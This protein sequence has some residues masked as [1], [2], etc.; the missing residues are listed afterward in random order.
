MQINTMSVYW[1]ARPESAE[2]CT[3]RL[4]ACFAEL[5]IHFPQ[6]AD[7]Y[8][9]GVKKATVISE[10]PVNKWNENALLEFVAASVNR[11]DIGEEAIVALGFSFGLCNISDMGDSGMSVTCGLFSPNPGLSNSVVVKL[12]KDLQTVSLDAIESQKR[13]LL[14]LVKAWNADW[15]AGYSSHSAVVKQRRNS[16]PF[17][18]KILWLR[19]GEG[20]PREVAESMTSEA[21]MEGTLYVK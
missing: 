20:L 19:D 15:G 7:W 16:G 10:D 5:A 8:Q 2:K 18:D 6:M 12:P 13:F 14:L 4:A 11:Q 17:F 9:K 1:R 21:V 3:A